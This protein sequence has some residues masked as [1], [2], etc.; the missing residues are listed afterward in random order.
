MVERISNKNEKIIDGLEI[1]NHYPG[2]YSYSRIFNKLAHRVERKDAYGESHSKVIDGFEDVIEG[3]LGESLFYNTQ[4]AA[5]QLAFSISL[6]THSAI[7]E[8]LEDERVSGADAVRIFRKERILEGLKIVDLGCGVPTFAVAAGALGG[9]SYTVDVEDI[10]PKYL[11]FIA[12][13]VVADLNDSDIL[14]KL[15]GELGGEFDLVTE[16]IISG[17]PFQS[18]R[19]L[20]R[21]VP[22]ET[23]ERIALLLSK[24]G[25]YLY[26]PTMLGNDILRKK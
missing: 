1:V 20:I 16:N 21:D 6:S 23:I 22:H 8:V 3:S 2:K 26:R 12:K 17:V 15:K 19:H 7:A 4:G 18:K 24:K 5:Y 9:T 14:E 10:A 25:G 13:H 11:A